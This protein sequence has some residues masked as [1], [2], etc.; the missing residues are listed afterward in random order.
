MHKAQARA[1]PSTMEI[2]HHPSIA[3]LYQQG[4]ERFEGVC[5]VLET[6]GYQN[7]Y[8]NMIPLLSDELGRLRVWAGNCGA[9]RMPSSRLSLDHRLREASHIQKRVKE[10]LM[11]LTKSLKDGKNPN[12]VKFQSIYANIFSSG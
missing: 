7:S 1:A 12:D 4:I 5:R 9:H 8:K 10:L 2:V 11:E 3:S 6:P